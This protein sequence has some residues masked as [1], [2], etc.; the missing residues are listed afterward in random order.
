MDRLP[1]EI[2]TQ[3][4]KLLHQQDK[5][6]CMRVCQ[7]WENT[8][9]RTSLFHTVRVTSKK[10]LDDLLQKAQAPVMLRVKRIILDLY[11]DSD[12]N[13]DILFSLFPYIKVLVAFHAHGSYHSTS[14]PWHNQIEFITEHNSNIHTRSILSGGICRRLETIAVI[15][16]EMQSGRGF[17]QLLKNAP[18][19]K[20]LS[21][22]RFTLSL[23]DLELL[24][25]HAPL[26]HSLSLQRIKINGG[27]DCLPCNRAITPAV[28]MSSFI[29]EKAINSVHKGKMA[30]AQYIQKKYTHLS[31]LVYDMRDMYGL[32][33][34]D[35]NKHGFVPLMERLGYQLRLLSVGWEMLDFNAFDM[36][37][38]HC[39]IQKWTLDSTIKEPLFEQLLCSHRAKSIQ[40]L[41]LSGY[42]KWTTLQNL[43]QFTMLKELCLSGLG[44][45]R[46]VLHLGEILAILGGDT[47]LETLQL[48][49]CEFTFEL[50][51]TM[52]KYHRLRNLTFNRVD[53]PEQLDAFIA[54]SFPK[55]RTLTLERCHLDRNRAFYMPNIDLFRLEIVD[56]FLD[57]NSGMLLI[58]TGNRH[59][60]L[61]TAYPI[62]YNSYSILNT[63]H[64]DSSLYP[65]IKSFPVL[66]NFEKPMMNLVCNSVVNVFLIN[67]LD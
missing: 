10:Q 51:S 58:Q 45:K 1:T 16:E 5:V 25:Q 29:I 2:L 54:M 12:F 56:S 60:R 66:G 40:S 27:G 18:A 11:L 35:E 50:R 8:I 43:R 41:T 65:A 38:S 47:L 55:L 21:M 32:D 67:A 62:A 44:L 57:E 49:D 9:S 39:R 6:E 19:L 7:H 33:V 42:L 17:I 53:L 46:R 36:L 63:S 31:E 14:N 13:M 52:N 30:L 34:D 20:T 23:M 59:Q 24:H 4:F 22:A 48:H 61:Y 3:I 28:G 37:D 64:L 26:L 15:G